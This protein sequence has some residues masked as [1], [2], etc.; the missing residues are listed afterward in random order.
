M[1]VECVKCGMD[2]IWYAKKGDRVSEARCTCGGRVRMIPCVP[3]A[4]CGKRTR[5]PRRP[6]FRWQA[7][8]RQTRQLGLIVHEP[9]RSCCWRHNPIPYTEVR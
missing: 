2:Q 8:D 7:E 3:C 9:M 1:R 5:E 4:E 6:R